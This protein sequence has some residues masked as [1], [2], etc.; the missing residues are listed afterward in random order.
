MSAARL[1]DEVFIK[2]FAVRQTQIHIKRNRLVS[3]KMRAQILRSVLSFCII[4]R[5]QFRL[6]NMQP[7][8]SLLM[9]LISAYHTLQG[10]GRV[11]RSF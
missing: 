11:R 1:T 9:H 4:F 6:R 7:P 2:S 10:E 5:V 8:Q 3:R